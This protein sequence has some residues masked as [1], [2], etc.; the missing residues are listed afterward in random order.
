M[1][2]GGGSSSTTVVNTPAPRSAEEV[3][4]DQLRL[5]EMQRQNDLAEALLPNQRALIEQQRAL[6]D[7]QMK[8]QGKLDEY[9]DSQLKLAQLQ[10][11]AS[12]RDQAMQEQL[13]PMQ[14]QFLQSQNQL[15]IQQIESTKQTMAFNDENNKYI[16]ENARD[17]HNRLV[18]R[19]KAYSPEEEANAA[20]EEARRASRMGALSEEAAN[21]QLEA[22]KRNGKPTDEQAAFLNQAY[23]AAQKTGESDISRYLQQ[24]LRTINEETAQAAGLRSTDSP[25]LRLSERAGEEA[26]RA[27]GDLATDIA[28]K[29]AAAMVSA[30]MG[31][32]QLQGAG[33]ANLQS[34]AGTQAQA[35]NQVL[36]AQAANN[37]NVAFNMPQPT[38]FAMPQAGGNANISFM[39]PAGQVQLNPNSLGLQV[40]ISH[41]GGTKQT[42]GRTSQWGVN[43]ADAGKVASGIGSMM[44]LSDARAKDSVVPMGKTKG[45]AA[46]YSYHYKG[47]KQ[48]RIGVMA[49]EV[50]R[51][52]P[53]AVVETPSGFLA[54]D[55]AK[56]K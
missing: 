29:K 13:A 52:F 34:L 40:G 10:I 22:L 30:G 7:Y 2:R 15:A 23:D 35:Y 27:Q 18:A 6:I 9:Q 50:R 1:S 54:V 47:D 8:N 20:A 53:D 44:A 25:T 33:A 3:Q 41:Q 11:Q 39:N 37:R 12:I 38:G 36:A 51:I 17:A 46:L 49:Q 21:I 14:L 19:Q 16:L 5:A 55:Y 28:G 31:L 45:G 32:Q 4:A 26:A 42:N 43:L 48:V 24:T 56:V